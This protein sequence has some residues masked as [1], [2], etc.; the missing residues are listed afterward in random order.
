MQKSIFRYPGG[1][2]RN[3]P[4]REIMGRFPSEFAEYRE[5]FIGGGG[6]YF[7]LDPSVKRW[8]NDRNEGLVAVYEALRDR[9]QEFIQTC[10]QIPVLSQLEKSSDAG[11]ESGKERLEKTF[12]DMMQ[13]PDADPAV[14]WFFRN[15]TGFSG[16]V[17]GDKVSVSSPERWNV[18][19]GDRLEEAAN[20]LTNTQITCGDFLPLLEA[21]GDDVFVYLDPPYRCDTDRPPKSRLYAHS[22]EL[23]DHERLADA[24]DHCPHKFLLSYD[25]VPWVRNRYRDYTIFEAAWT[26]S[27]ANSRPIGKELII[28]NYAPPGM[29]E[30]GIE[31][32]A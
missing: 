15:R 13:F 8:I 7:A 6:I 32:A 18:V 4:R 30:R 10:R 19:N 12:K 14:R 17:S 27:V 22:F 29:Q 31:L 26:Y 3:A 2:S 24:L 5:P 20:V 28:T 21:P 16:R 11:R 9:P 25:D 23:E 1:K